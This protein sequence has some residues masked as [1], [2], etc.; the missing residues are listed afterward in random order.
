MVALTDSLS[1]VPA[2]SAG[3]TEISLMDSKEVGN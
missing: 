2:V 1:F 3:D